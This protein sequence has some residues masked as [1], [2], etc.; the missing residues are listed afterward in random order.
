M[1]KELIKE[2]LNKFGSDKEQFLFIL[3]Y[4]LSKFYIQK[5]STLPKNMKFQ[6]DSQVNVELK[7][8]I[9]LEKFPITFDEYKKKFDF[10]QE[11]IKKGN[12]YLCNLTAKTKIKTSFGLDEIYENVHAKFKLR[13]QNKNDNFVCFSPERFIEIKDNKIF[14]YPMKGT[15]DN[16]IPNAQDLILNDKKEMAEHTMVVDLLRNDLGIVGS[17]VRVDMFRYVEKINAGNKK[18]FQV[19]SKISANLQNNWHENIGDILTSLL[20]AGSITGTPKKKTIEILNKVEDY[21]RGFYTGI[22]G[23][24]DGENLDSSVMI[25]FIEIDKKG[26]LFYKSGGGITCDSNVELEYQELLDKI[27]LPF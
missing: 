20:P 16:S 22:F 13:F 21:D 23:F 4:D 15:I 11:E 3:S 7:R 2:K 14:T 17:K 8:K 1:S 10:L 9:V 5:L 24:F 6:I 12:S 26:E 19:S 25:R 18:L 27:Y